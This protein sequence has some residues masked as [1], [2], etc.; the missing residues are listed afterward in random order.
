MVS[1]TKA[2]ISDIFFYFPKLETRVSSN[3]FSV[4]GSY[5][6]ETNFSVFDIGNIT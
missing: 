6:S 1:V 2:V 3:V 4:L 5:I